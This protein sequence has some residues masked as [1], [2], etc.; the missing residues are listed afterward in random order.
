MLK[1]CQKGKWTGQISQEVDDADIIVVDAATVDPYWIKHATAYVITYDY[2][3]AARRMSLFGKDGIPALSD[4][5]FLKC[6]S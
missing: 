2:F 5:C 3:V 6:V 1:R 4:Y